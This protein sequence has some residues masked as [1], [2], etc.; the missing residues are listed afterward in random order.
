MVAPWGE[1]VALTMSMTAD[2]TT[3]NQS[4]REVLTRAKRLV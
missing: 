4:L 2:L 1:A 3:A